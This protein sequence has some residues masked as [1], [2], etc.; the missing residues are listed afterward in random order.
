MA[1][2]EQGSCNLLYSD[3]EI[4]AVYD[5]GYGK[6]RPGLDDEETL[7]QNISASPMIIIS[8]WDLDHY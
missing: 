4:K 5:L 6:G 3:N 1:N 2:I 8:H 7:I